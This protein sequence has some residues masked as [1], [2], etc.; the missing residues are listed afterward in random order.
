[1]C[2]GRRAHSFLFCL[3]LCLGICINFSKSDFDLIT[4]LFFLGLCLDTVEMCVSQSSDKLNEMQQSAHSLLQ[5]QPVKE[6][7]RSC[8]C[9]SK[10]FRCYSCVC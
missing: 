4:A 6:S 8:L 2:A 9:I 10:T 3:L 5:K 1:M 7:V